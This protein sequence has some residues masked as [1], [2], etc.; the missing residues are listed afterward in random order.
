[1]YMDTGF[2]VTFT[3]TAYMR[4]IFTKMINEMNVLPNLIINRKKKIIKNEL[5]HEKN[6]QSAY[7]KTDVDQCL[8][9]HCTD[10]TIPL[11]SKYKISS[12]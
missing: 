6:Q 5:H 9:F 1:M 8:C 10:S 2:Y 4:A 12:L 7:A 3:F 11:L